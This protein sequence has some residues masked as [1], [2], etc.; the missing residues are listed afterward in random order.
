MKVRLFLM[1]AVLIT[2]T[3]GLWA[4]DEKAVENT[5]DN[6][7]QS[8]RTVTITISPETT[9]ITEPLLPDGRVDY[10]GA[11]HLQNSVGITKENN[12][13]PAILAIIPGEKESSFIFYP[14]DYDRVR[15][16]VED[17]RQRYWQC[18]GF[19]APPP[20][21]SLRFLRP[22]VKQGEE[23]E[24][25]LKYYTPEEIIPRLDE[26]ERPQEEGVDPLEYLKKLQEGENRWWLRS[27]VSYDWNQALNR[28]W[29]DE[30]YPLLA[31]W[32]KTANNL[33]Q[34]L[35]DASRRPRFYNPIITSSEEDTF[36]YS[37][38]LPY[39]QAMREAARF[40]SVRGNWHF[41]SGEYDE[42]F[43][44]AF[45][46]QRI[47]LAIRTNNCFI[48][49][50]LVGV[51]ICGIANH[52]VMT[53]L[54]ALD[55]KKDTQWLAAKRAEFAANLKAYPPPEIP[56]WINWERCGMLSA[57]QA[58]EIKTDEFGQLF[59][60][61]S[62]NEE[63]KENTAARRLMTMLLDKDANYDW[64][65]VLRLA[66]GY[67]DE[68]EDVLYLPGYIRK[69]RAIARIENRMVALSKEL[70]TRSSDS[71]PEQFI[72]DSLYC[73]TCPALNAVT[74][75]L[76]RAKF[77]ARAVDVTFALAMYRT[78]RGEYSETLEQLV[79]KYL[80]AVPVSSFSEKPIRY[81]KRDN[82]LLLS[83]FDDYPLDG[84]D[85]AVEKAIVDFRSDPKFQYEVDT[86]ILYHDKMMII[87]VLHY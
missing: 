75:A 61:N 70:K 50:D 35:I 46:T 54:M 62:L 56:K 71:D 20:L 32:N 12:M 67:F 40:L 27:A 7:K 85:E 52:R 30:D 43:E 38:L 68:L 25:L 16:E 37:A 39:V 49:E 84:S 21:E 5:V 18:L 59:D 19:D 11:M 58:I 55:G 47:G 87:Y 31:D 45:A 34:K 3:M 33:E 81:F 10:Y 77:D 60:D 23:L 28:L 2:G 13:M 63:Q 15:K 69:D 14:E 42:A 79:P 8:P 64:D 1:L 9:Y 82:M 24:Y 29:T 83:A 51:A 80:D 41:A 26:D 73:L 36:V 86:V 74:K 4:E 53:Y 44:C 17:Y 78:D 57:V 66:N 72:A 76:T 22:E 6:A 65:K 48:V